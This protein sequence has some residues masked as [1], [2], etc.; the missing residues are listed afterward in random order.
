MSCDFDRA[1]KDHRCLFWSGSCSLAF[2][3][4]NGDGLQLDFTTLKMYKYKKK[5]CIQKK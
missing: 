1:K 3:L 5:I 2:D 4:L